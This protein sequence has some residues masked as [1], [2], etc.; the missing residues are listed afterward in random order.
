MK[1]EDCF[2]VVQ[3][4]WGD[5]TGKEELMCDKKKWIDRERLRIYT[6]LAIDVSIA[7]PFVK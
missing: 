4:S 1:V 6:N 5:E 7:E 2:D 3:L